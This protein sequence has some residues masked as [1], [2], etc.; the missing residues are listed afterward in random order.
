M[1][2]VSTIILTRNN[3]PHTQRCL[4]SIFRYSKYPY[5]EVIVVDNG[6]TD[7][8]KDY[9]RELRSTH[10]ELTY[11]LNAR[12]LGFAAG[13]NLGIRQA[14][15][16]Y[17]ILLNNDTVVTEGW[18]AGLLK[19]FADPAVGMVGPVSNSVGNEAKI[20]LVF[21]SL[22]EMHRAAGAYTAANRNRSFEI[23]MLGFFCVA[24]RREVIANVGFL[25]EQFSLGQFEDDDYCLRV[26]A[27]NYKIICAE[28]VF[29]YHHGGVSFMK[30][31]P[32]QYF[33]VT[34]KNKRYFE[35][36]WNRRWVTHG[37]G[38]GLVRTLLRDSRE[39]VQQQV[40]SARGQAASADLQ[41]FL[42][43]QVGRLQALQEILETR[44]GDPEFAYGSLAWK[45]TRLQARLRRLKKIFPNRWKVALRDNY[46]SLRSYPVYR[47]LRQAVSNQ[48]TQILDRT[49]SRRGVIVFYSVC[50]WSY[51]LFQRP[52]QLA[53]ALAKQNYLV[54]Y[55]T[56]NRGE[57]V[58]GLSRVNDLLYLVND[59]KFL[60]G[61]PAVV[62]LTNHPPYARFGPCLNTTLMV[63]DFMDDLE[64]NKSLGRRYQRDHRRLLR[65]VNLVT[66][67]SD[68]L[69]AQ[70]KIT[71]TNVV[72]IP[73][74]VDYAHFSLTGESACPADLLPL[75]RTGQP[76]IGYYGAFGDWLDFPLLQLLARHYR[77]CHVVLIGADFLDNVS[78]HRLPLVENIHWLGPKP[79]QELPA[80]LHRFDT[81]I[82]PFRSGPIAASTS[83]VKLFEYMAAG[84]PVVTTDIRECRKYP[85]VLVSDSQQIFLQN[86]AKALGLKD[87][88]AYR[89]ALRTESMR[90]TWDI[91]AQTLLAAVQR[92]TG[93]A[94]TSAVGD[95]ART[96]SV[97][98]GTWEITA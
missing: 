52:H 85:G 84:I 42:A 32:F 48:L 72:V 62:F 4:E 94:P 45:I 9:L 66:V 53:L 24:I 10:Q 98:G 60:S 27:A 91:R 22:E 63:Y 93:K 47:A 59:H 35:T 82:I 83:P 31:N 69:E 30:L 15:G 20:G 40:A 7:G 14:K 75:V 58:R 80:Y 61:V 13:N 29:V 67:T 96:A 33:R 16:D 77:Q 71:N 78:R 73:N 88:A 11:L 64:V 90:H 12:N 28:D 1:T 38:L 49:V 6:S 3:L 26:K 18:I 23:P 65:Q 74:G 86:V 97:G 68:A 79:Y 19:Y 36:K 37:T 57:N 17:L 89:A 95:S 56:P 39:F 44:A 81:A 54:F 41:G 46:T 8:T 55:R 21:T 76:I 51:P 25:D 70:V 87:D 50:D 5:H 92:L 43:R 34:M 2:L